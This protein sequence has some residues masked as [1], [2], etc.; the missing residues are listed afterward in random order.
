MVMK[1]KKCDVIFSSSVYPL[2]KCPFC[3]EKLS[4]ATLES[5]EGQFLD[6]HV[7]CTKKPFIDII[8]YVEDRQVGATQEALDELIEKTEG[9]IKETQEREKA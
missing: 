8:K 4:Q 5:N 3:G 6:S 7:T 9:D 1:C 2:E